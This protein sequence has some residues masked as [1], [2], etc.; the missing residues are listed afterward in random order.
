MAIKV[1]R[2]DA[3]ARPFAPAD[4]AGF[5]R[6]LR[7]FYPDEC[8]GKC[9]D[10]RQTASVKAIGDELDAFVAAHP[11]FDV[12]D[13]RR[14]LYLSIRRHFI[15]YILP[16]SPFYCESGVNGGWCVWRGA[17]SVPGQHVK[18]IC[19][20][21]F[22][23]RHLIPKEAFDVKSAR[24]G[25]R[26]SLVGTFV[27]DSHHIPPF[28][29][30]FSKGFRGVRQEAA[31][32]LAKC[33]ANDPRGRKLLETAIVGLDTV[34]EM[35][36]RFAEE[37]RRQLA[38]DGLA[39]DDRR[40]LQRIADAAMRCP[41]EPPR[42]FY[43]GLNTL[44]FVR[45]TL[46][47]VDGTLNFSLGRP[48]AWLDG[49]LK[50]DIAA[51]RIDWPE[52]RDL[53]ARFLVTADCH[54]DDRL[55]ID[56]YSDQ[57]AELPL[58]LGGCDS[59]G[60]PVYNELTRMFLDA[61]I[62]LDLVFPKLHCRISEGSPREYLEQIGS[63]LMRGHAVFALFN[64]D[65][66]I[67]NYL[68]MG[69]PVERARDYVCCGCWDGNVDSDTCVDTANYMSVV[70]ILELT[71]HRDPAMERAA[72][73]RIDPIDGAKTFE[74]VRDTLYHNFIRFLRDN[75]SDY[76]RYG[77]RNAE[78]NAKPVYSACL[79][80]CIASR[81]DALEGGARFNPRIITL[82]FLANVVDS[83]CAI[84]K[85]CFEDR[86]ATLPELL[87]AVRSNWKGPKGERLR[88]AALAAPYWG[89]N[90][91]ASNALMRFWI[92]G[93]AADIEGFANDKGGPYVLACWIY[94]EFILWGLKTKAT[95]DGRHDGDR[96]AQ[97]F[98]PSEYR[99]KSDVTTV[100]NSLGAIDHSRLYASNANLS[101]DKTIMSTGLFAS[102]FRV[103]CRK[104]M[105]LLQP[106]CNSVEDLLDAQRHP[107]RHQNLI[108]K[109]CGYSARFISLSKRYQ[110]EVIARHR[111]R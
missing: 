4:Y 31:E 101:F 60:R 30:V 110:D 52:V 18:R 39:A 65:R 24:V 87:A 16:G 83:L 15:P 22:Q 59:E 67:P 55:Q 21:F 92:D 57:E 111:L 8:H 6:G 75:L 7:A 102:I 28:K 76:T 105:H 14:E 64:D 50:A 69:Y 27:D 11:D 98:S 41:W 9:K 63:M 46:G 36:L 2:V 49:F 13:V 20:R 12:L 70:R 25:G 48:D 42:T 73:I 94:R 29:T 26:F 79:S 62:D 90:S 107:E 99:C 97:G 100:L 3:A 74:E 54:L 109:V 5:R 68:A 91:E 95:P 33:P 81:R 96:L 45:E 38:A 71:I 88:L 43:E 17:E 66:H 84:R 106:N 40:R 80:G 72:R 58:T 77:A 37:A 35:Q 51:G 108:V 23:S 19:S 104:G 86:L 61:H 103:A 10:P 56:A 93:V 1:M 47:Y 85:I 44:W 53:V 89:D 34:H 32:A 78:V 82:A